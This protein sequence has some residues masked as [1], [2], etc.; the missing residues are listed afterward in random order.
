MPL[1]DSESFFLESGVP[2]DPIV[3]GRY[4]IEGQDYTRASTMAKTL[5]TEFGVHQWETERA[6][7]GVC[8]RPDLV[9]LAHSTDVTD[10]RALKPLVADALVI[11][12]R[13]AAAN[14]G[15]A[16]HQYA[17]SVLTGKI[18][19]SDVPD[20]YRPCITALTVELQRLGCTV[21][22]TE[23][24]VTNTIA[25]SAGRYDL[26]LVDAQG[27]HLI[28]DLKFGKTDRHGLEFSQQLAIYNHADHWG[29]EMRRD[30]AIVFDM[31]LEHG[32]CFPLDVNTT[33]GWEYVQISTRVRNGRNR[34]DLVLPHHDDASFVPMPYASVEQAPVPSVIDQ[35]P[36][37]VAPA[38]AATL[39]DPGLTV[40][41]VVT[42]DSGA[43]IQ[44]DMINTMPAQEHAEPGAVGKNHPD[45][46]ALMAQYKAKSEMQSAAKS[47]SMGIKLEAYRVNIAIA[48]VSSDAWPSHRSRLLPPAG[49]IP[50]PVPSPLDGVAP[51]LSPQAQ[52]IVDNVA[53]IQ[54]GM[55][56]TPGQPV[57]TPPAPIAIQPEPDA[58]PVDNPFAQAPVS[59][60]EHFK[61]RID[62]AQRQVDIA[63]LFDEGQTA[64]VWDD[65]LQSHAMNKFSTL[66]S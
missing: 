31:S 1:S 16:G 7:W 35:Q 58:V 5:S 28:G 63:S 8:Q 4:R 40:D 47:M 24:I 49:Q 13:D 11:G 55:V 19:L 6:V 38:P 33:A 65:E 29:P 10:R 27:F 12:K 18:S 57:S 26:E 15:T 39:T 43:A 46:V 32:T 42:D 22:S 51:T 56:V 36:A 23:Q 17:V 14:E 53:S 48:M 66:T 61:A 20:R 41:H 45:V 44:A 50:A 37:S 54:E 60:K 64:G 2:D 34:T 59:P 9:A 52:R 62:A 30:L 21:V 3:N 25:G